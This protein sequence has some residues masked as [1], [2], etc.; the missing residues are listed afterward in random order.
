MNTTSYPKLVKALREVLGPDKLLTL[1][2]YEEPTEYFW[3][4]E[5]T[6]GIKVGEYLDYAWTGYCDED[7]PFEIVDPYH[8]DD[9][10]VSKEHI[11]KPIAGLDATKF[12]CINAPWQKGP[13]T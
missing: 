1:T 8:P 10:N 11:R 2:D 9:P 12:G 6:G 3:D 4:T 5:A 7:Y 13:R